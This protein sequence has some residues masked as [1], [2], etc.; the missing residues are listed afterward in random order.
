MRTAITLG[1]AHGSSIW[2]M[3]Y[4]PETSIAEQR[5]ALKA[6]RGRKEH[7]RWAEL[8]LWESDTGVLSRGKYSA[9]AEVAAAIAAKVPAAAPVDPSEPEPAAP[10][11][12]A[13]KS[14]FVV[15]GTSKRNRR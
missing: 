14:D 8:Q 5:A 13:E 9:P 11:P 3:V 1:L 15:T 2:E 7:P 12:D 6:T 10:A 4:G